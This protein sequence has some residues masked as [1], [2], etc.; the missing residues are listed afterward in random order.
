MSQA[1]KDD[2]FGR[3]VRPENTPAYFLTSSQLESFVRGSRGAESSLMEADKEKDEK[4]KVIVQGL[5]PSLRIP[6]EYHIFKLLLSTVI[7][8]KG[9]QKS[10]VIDQSQ[11]RYTQYL[12]KVLK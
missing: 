9:Q 2:S 10:T 4:E 7:G 12:E 6:K 3:R 11:K 8:I 1:S 5:L